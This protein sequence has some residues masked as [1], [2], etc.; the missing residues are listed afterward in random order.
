MS[1]FLV[2]IIIAIDG[3]MFSAPIAD[4]IAAVLCIFFIVREFKN[5]GKER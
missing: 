4:G 5:M 3:V 1:T 2:V